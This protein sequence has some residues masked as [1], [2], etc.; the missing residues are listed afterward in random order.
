MVDFTN[1]TFDE[2][3]IYADAYD[4]DFKATG[5]IKVHRREEIFETDC[6]VTN[7]FQKAA[8]HLRIKVNK[9]KVKQN[10][11]YPIVWG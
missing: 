10:D 1:I 2:D 7:Q 11:S 5:K 8:W 6:K 3:W 4:V 9:G